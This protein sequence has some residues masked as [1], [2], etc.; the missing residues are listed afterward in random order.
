[1]KR[2]DHIAL[3]TSVVII[4][5]ISNRSL[6]SQHPVPPLASRSSTLENV[7]ISFVAP[8]IFILV[9]V[10]A[11]IK[12]TQFVNKHQSNTNPD[13]GSRSDEPRIARTQEPAL[14]VGMRVGPTENVPAVTRR[15]GKCPTCGT[16]WPLESAK[17]EHLDWEEVDAYPYYCPKCFRGTADP[18]FN[19]GLLR[20][21]D[22]NPVIDQQDWR[23][24]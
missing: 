23:R 16:V 19:R 17:R 24:G 10:Y 11:V 15:A 3:F 8:A 4:I 20:G 21:S 14:T 5:T 13:P 12:L 7:L 2:P 18:H 9:A 22:G 1:M 6:F